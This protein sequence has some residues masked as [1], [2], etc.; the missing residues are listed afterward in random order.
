MLAKEPLK[1]DE[2]LHI[3]TYIITF[4]F[5]VMRYILTYI[6]KK[7]VDGI[8]IAD[9]IVG[10]SLLIILTLPFIINIEGATNPL[11]IIIGIL[12]LVNFILP[13]F[14][15]SKTTTDFFTTICFFMIFARTI[16]IF[17]N[18]GYWFF[19]V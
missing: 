15:Y 10:F 12:W 18:M 9:M 13:L 6:D 5:T 7:F 3:T 4:V 2:K 19:H 1:I 8:F 14:V 16:S 17:G 11:L